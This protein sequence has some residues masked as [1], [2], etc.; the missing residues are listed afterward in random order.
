MDTQE[1]CMRL[2]ITAM[3]KIQKAFHRW[4]CKYLSG[5]VQELKRSLHDKSVFEKVLAGKKL[6]DVGSSTKGPASKPAPAENICPSP[7]VDVNELDSIVPNPASSIVCCMC[8]QMGERKVLLSSKQHPIAE[9]KTYP[10]PRCDV[11]SRELRPLEFRSV[12]D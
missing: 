9:R 7:T 11:R 3:L 5:K 10:V 2:E 4:M 8:H 1:R 6:E 12:R